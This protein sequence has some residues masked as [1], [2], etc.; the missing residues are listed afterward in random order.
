[1]SDGLHIVVTSL[2]YGLL[3]L[4]WFRVAF[5]DASVNTTGRVRRE[6]LLIGY[7]ES[8]VVSSV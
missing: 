5:I 7:F 4:R 1:M 2:H 3:L 8:S 6:R